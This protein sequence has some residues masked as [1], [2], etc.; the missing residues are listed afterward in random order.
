MNFLEETISEL[1]RILRNKYFRLRLRKSQMRLAQ[2][3]IKQKEVFSKL[4]GRFSKNYHLLK[5]YNIDE[6]T[7]PLWKKF[8]IRLEK[9]L[10][11]Y[12][13]FSFLEDPTI[14]FTMFATAGGEWLKKELAFLENKIPQKQL[15]FILEEDYLGDPLLLSSEYLTSHTTIHHLY[16][17]IKFLEVTRSRLSDFKTIVEWGGGY[18]NMIKILKRWDKGPAT[19]IMIDT[20]LLCCLQW[21]YLAT[22]FGERNTLFITDPSQKIKANKINILPLPLVDSQKIK[23]DLFISTWALSESSEYSQDYVI[24]NN[25]FEAKHLLLAYQENPAGFFNPLRVGEL[26]KEKGAKIEK[27]EF[28][29]GNYYA[30]L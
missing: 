17:L 12:P 5:K 26:A 2:N 19:Y 30:F 18:G 21:L 14:M 27:I 3:K 13:S 6:Y 25:W 8:N 22:I 4:C 24:K 20:P 10:L 16:H 29:P 11:P 15:K 1:L 7:T 28:L 23:A 9:A